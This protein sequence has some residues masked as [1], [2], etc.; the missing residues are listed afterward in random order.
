MKPSEIMTESEKHLIA[1]E[2]ANILSQKG[3][4]YSQAVEILKDTKKEIRKIPFISLDSNSNCK[5]T[6]R[7][8]VK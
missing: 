6:E 7:P 5:Y 4:S 3:V 1:K 2:I 8:D